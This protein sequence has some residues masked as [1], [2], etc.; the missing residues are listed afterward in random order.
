MEEREEGEGEGGRLRKRSSSWGHFCRVL[1][2]P[3]RE[4]TVEQPN[5]AS[6]FGPLC[7]LA[8]ERSAGGCVSVRVGTS[9]HA[10]GCV[11]VSQRKDGCVR[12]CVSE[13]ERGGC[14]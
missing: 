10:C 3:N 2:A 13:R 7:H 9:L 6:S 1:F 4:W 11:C 8:Q 14:I 12:V 5:E